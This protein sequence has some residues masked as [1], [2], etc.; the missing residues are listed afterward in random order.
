VPAVD[1]VVPPPWRTSWFL[2][3]PSAFRRSLVGWTP[4]DLRVAITLAK[5]WNFP[6]VSASYVVTFHFK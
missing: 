6:R 3:F 4:Y 2:V 5:S 1:P